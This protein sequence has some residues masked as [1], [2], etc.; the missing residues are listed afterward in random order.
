MKKRWLTGYYEKLALCQ[1]PIMI[2]STAWRD[3]RRYAFSGFFNGC[4]ISHAG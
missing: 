2:L 1:I 4:A 3:Y